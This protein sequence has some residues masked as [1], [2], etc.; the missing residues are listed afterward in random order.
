MF[1]PRHPRATIR[2][3]GN[4][5]SYEKADAFER[6]RIRASNPEGLARGRDAARGIEAWLAKRK[7]R[8]LHGFD[9]QAAKK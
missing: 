9:Q 3:F 6:V 8:E 1:V 4:G 5:Q 7:I 2:S